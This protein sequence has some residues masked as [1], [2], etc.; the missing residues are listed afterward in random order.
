MQ[1]HQLQEARAHFSS[2]I[3][4]ALNGEPQRITRRG[5][6]AVIIVSE[7]EWNQMKQRQ[8]SFGD[9]LAGFPG[10]DDTPLMDGNTLRKRDD[11][12]NPFSDRT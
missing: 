6:E 4:K 8:L 3:D 7:A 11:R 2:V 9:F 10:F 12:G 5:K 1:N